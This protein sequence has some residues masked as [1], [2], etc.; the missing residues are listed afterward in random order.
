MSLL[1]GVL[2]KKKK[3]LIKWVIGAKFD[4]SILHKRD[5]SQV[6]IISPSNKNNTYESIYQKIRLKSD[7]G[8]VTNSNL[9][10]TGWW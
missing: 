6:R 2:Q 10:I 7:L 1:T 9:S 3:F 8:R 5:L 4:S